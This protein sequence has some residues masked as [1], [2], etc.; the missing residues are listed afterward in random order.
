[1]AEAPGGIGLPGLTSV[2]MALVMPPPRTMSTLAISMMESE[3]GSV[4]VVSRSITRINGLAP[5]ALLS[6]PAGRY[7]RQG[8][9]GRDVAGAPLFPGIL[10]QGIRGCPKRRR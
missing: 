8:I 2:S 5:K 7:G 3:A 10:F 6:I 1:M 9:G 4:P